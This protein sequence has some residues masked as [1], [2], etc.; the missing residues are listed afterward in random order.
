MVACGVPVRKGGDVS[1]IKDRMQDAK[2]MADNGLHDAAIQLLRDSL[3]TI[4]PGGDYM[5]AADIHLL[6]M[7]IEKQRLRATPSHVDVTE[8]HPA[9]NGNVHD[10]EPAH[11]PRSL[12]S[13]ERQPSPRPAP[14][15]ASAPADEA[16]RA[17]AA[18]SKALETGDQFSA[19]QQLLSARRSFS[20]AGNTG[21]VAK[22]DEAIAKIK[23]TSDSSNESFTGTTS[24]QAEPARRVQ[25]PAIASSAPEGMVHVLKEAMAAKERGNYKLALEKFQAILHG[26][27]GPERA[28]IERQVRRLRNLIS[29]QEVMTSS[30]PLPGTSFARTSGDLETAPNGA[31]DGQVAPR[32]GFSRPA[33]PVDREDR[34]KIQKRYAAERLIVDAENCD[35]LVEAIEKL[36]DAAHLHLV[37]GT[38]R[39]RVEWIYEKINTL[40]RHGIKK[41]VGLFEIEQFSPSMLRDYAFTQIDKAKHEARF[42]HYKPALSHYSRSVSALVKAGW[43]QDQVQ[44]I[45]NDMVAIRKQQDLVEIEEVRL[46]EAINVEIL[47]LLDNLDGWRAGRMIDIA[48]VASIDEN[49]HRPGREKSVRE[50][51]VERMLDIQ[52][53]REGK[54]AAMSRA[55]DEA[56]HLA[57]I[58]RYEAARL[59]YNRAL[60]F[61]DELGGWDIQK[62]VILDEIGNL[63]ALEERQREL[64]EFRK[65]KV[66][67][68]REQER[69]DL[70]ERFFLMKQAAAL[71]Q[72]NLKEQLL[73]KRLRDEKE[74]TVFDILI[75]LANKLKKQGKLQDC[76]VEFK[77]ALKLLVEAGW[78]T[79]TQSLRDE[80]ADLE[81]TIASSHPAPYGSSDRRVTRDEVFES[82]MPAAR[83]ATS[84]GNFLEARN[85]YQ[86]AIDKLRSIGWE[87]YIAPIVES[88]NDIESKIQD[89]CEETRQVAH[90]TASGGSKQ[91]LEMGFRFLAK[92]MKKYALVEFSKALAVA[93]DE[94]DGAI[95]TELQKQIKKLEFEVKLEESQELLM[96]RKKNAA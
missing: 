66:A 14:V 83:K 26:A 24:R 1:L 95:I 70:E 3:A 40:K 88:I 12:P 8:L 85:L 20:K 2:R 53:T 34:D 59:E 84:C 29:M 72:E 74:K 81:A 63:K 36:Q 17:W 82:I 38:S 94:K 50:K 46:Q 21:M 73:M 27:M 67:S 16:M 43:V 7:D 44:Y 18:A 9:P 51:H 69:Q 11:V 35:N 4:D 96:Q 39:D 62:N 60:E 25:Q 30:T 80:I 33:T 77:E 5:A 15:A 71:N 47:H 13:Q 45:I 89:A 6:I 42:G 93:M 22:V 68:H 52:R 28:E 92:D 54:K 79:Q 31:V 76:L 90:E 48:P 32:A 78:T 41:N 61:M 65:D 75:P 91:H 56:R 19:R 49:V 58:G 55:L 57:D 87:E 64:T 10:H 23:G 37:T 86:L